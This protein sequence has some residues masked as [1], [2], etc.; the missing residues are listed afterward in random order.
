MYRKNK[1]N[2]IMRILVSIL[3]V[4]KRTFNLLKNGV[5]EKRHWPP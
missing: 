1:E 3:Y 2:N 5:K 4:F